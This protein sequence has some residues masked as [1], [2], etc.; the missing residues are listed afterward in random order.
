MQWREE[1]TEKPIQAEY[2][3]RQYKGN[4]IT[5]Y[6]LKDTNGTIKVIKAEDLKHLIRNGHIEVM[7]LKLTSNNRLLVLDKTVG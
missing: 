1:P 2:I 7:N 3:K 4:K 6:I 5:S